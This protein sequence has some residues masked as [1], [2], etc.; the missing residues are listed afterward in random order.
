[1]LYTGLPETLT[2]P[3]T[4]VLLSPVTPPLKHQ[5]ARLLWVLLVQ[6]LSLM[7]LS[8]LLLPAVA[9]PTSLPGPFSAVKNIGTCSRAKGGL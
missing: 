6:T 1:M 8:L 5:C 2:D 9:A 7:P 3:W 4:K